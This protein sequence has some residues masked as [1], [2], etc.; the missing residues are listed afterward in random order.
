M[1][2]T[3]SALHQPSE[4]DDE[5]DFTEDELRSKLK[6]YI[7]FIDNVLQPE[8]EKAVSHRE[9]VES[10]IQEYNE[11]KMNIQV[12][13]NKKQRI[14]ENKRQNNDNNNNNADDNADLLGEQMSMVDLGCQTAY[15]QAKINNPNTIFV[16]IG[17]GIHA[18]F[19]L[20]ESIS[21]I[22]KRIKF[23]ETNLLPGRVEKAKTVASHLEDALSLL[24]SLGKEIHAM[25]Q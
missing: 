20:E 6:E 18:E 9:E 24:E 16:D 12:F 3:S 13:I 1:T 8:L 19:T 10:E 14:K 2:S 11:L 22:E 23:L 7:H 15:C 4:F 21:V 25:E 5:P 17:K